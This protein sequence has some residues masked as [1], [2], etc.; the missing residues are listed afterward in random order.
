[1]LRKN[2][3]EHVRAGFSGIWVQSYEHDEAI[4]EIA[5]LCKDKTTNERVWHLLVWDMDRGLSADGNAP[6]GVDDPITPVRAMMNSP[7]NDGT[8]ILVLQNYHR[9]LDNL[10]IIQLLANAINTGKSD[11]KH[12]VIL[13]CEVKIPAELEKH[14]VVIDH[15]L[16]NRDM[17][18]EICAGM[19]LA[20]SDACLDAAAG[21]TCYEAEGAFALS[22]IRSPVK[23]TAQAD[24]VW[25][26]KAGALK[27]AGTLELHRGTEKFSDLGGLEGVKEFCV[28]ALGNNSS[29]AKARGI[30][31]LGVPGAGKSAFSKALGNEVGR[32]TITMDFGSLMGSLVGESEAKTRQALQVVDRMSPCI[33]F[34]DEIEKGLSGASGEHNGDSGVSQRMFGTLLTWLND[35]ESDVFF[36]GTCNDIKQLTSVS[37][38]AFTRAE[39]FDGI[40]FIDLPSEEQRLQ[41]WDM[42]KS[43]FSISADQQNA[44]LI[45]DTDWTGAEIKSCCR[46][47]SLLG[48]SLKEASEMVVPVARTAGAQIANLRE[49]A[50]GKALDANRRG[51]YSRQPAGNMPVAT[52]TRRRIG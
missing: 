44:S 17:L 14:F 20:Y 11:G 6:D 33:L 49:W 41:I 1:M 48:I 37:S 7:R 12:I 36:I 19:E 10:P 51:I 8:W 24:T 43:A 4:R 29:T 39:R 5:K 40:F 21:L 9:M 27:K 16:P 15:E 45:D 38:G 3:E 26:I 30:L 31:L 35:H 2:L 28:K 46:L 23:K 22:S 32:P 25:D 47:A 18:A 13:S 34:C 42:Y 52:S 50:D